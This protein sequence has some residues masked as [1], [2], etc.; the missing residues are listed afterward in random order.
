MLM[1]YGM[2]TSELSSFLLEILN[3]A[4]KIVRQIWLPVQANCWSENNEQATLNI[5][6]PYFDS[7]TNE[8]ISLYN[9]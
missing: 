4:W 8:N 6:M 7:T 5:N 2:L 9:K 1:E 3:D